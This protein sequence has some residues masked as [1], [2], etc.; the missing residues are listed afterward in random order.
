MFVERMLPMAREHLVTIPHDAPLMAAARLLDDHNFKLVVV[1]DA[2]G[3][4]VGVVTRADIVRQMG[5][6]NGGACATAA[7]TTMTRDVAFCRPSDHLRDVWSIMKERGLYHIPVIDENR[8]P[9]G[10]INARDA[11]LLLLEGSE[12]QETLLRDYVMGIGYH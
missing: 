6:C 1:C 2:A 3:R 11:L 7:A 12:Y 9:L 10:V 4:M 5:R 8:S